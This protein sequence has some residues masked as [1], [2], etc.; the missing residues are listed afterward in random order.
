MSAFV[1][2]N[3]LIYSIINAITPGPGNILALNT[4]SNYGL[5]KGSPLFAGI[6]VQYLFM[7]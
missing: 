3:F 1:I 4:V 7:V 2:G 5:K 6:F